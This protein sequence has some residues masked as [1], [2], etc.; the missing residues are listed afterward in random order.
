[1]R[2]SQFS[3]THIIQILKQYQSGT[4]I[5]E[6]CKQHNISKP[7]FYTWRTRFSLQLE[8]TKELEEENAKMHSRFRKLHNRLERISAEINVINNAIKQVIEK[9]AQS[10]DASSR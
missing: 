6:L 2:K 5:E 1:M 4:S 9:N 10:Q 8:R 7:T 3:E